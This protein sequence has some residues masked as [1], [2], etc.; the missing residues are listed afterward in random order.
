MC[1]NVGLQTSKSRDLD[2]VVEGRKASTKTSGW[3]E[4]KVENLT[5]W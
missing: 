3:R 4:A 2:G 1:K 5:A